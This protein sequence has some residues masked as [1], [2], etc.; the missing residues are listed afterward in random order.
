MPGYIRI[1]NISL[2]L[3]AFNTQSADLY[4][5][6]KDVT[7]S[8]YF[9][10]TTGSA[11]ATPL[12]SKAWLQLHSGQTADLAI[13]D[14]GFIVED[15]QLNEL[16]YGIANRLLAQWPGTVPD[17]AIF[18]LGDRSPL[19]YGAAMAH[20]RE[21]FVNYGVLL[22]AESEDELAAVIGHELSHIL[23]E[24]GKT[25]ELKKNMDNS[26]EL[27]G[28]ARDRYAMAEAIRYNAETIE[29]SIDPSV[30][31]D[32]KKSAEQKLVAD[33]LYARA[34]ATLFSRGNEHDADRLGLDLMVAAG[35]SPMGLKNSLE[36]MAHSYDL[37]TA[38]SEYF[39]SSSE[40]LLQK[41]LTAIDQA[42]E[43]NADK[44]QELNQF[45]TSTGEEFKASALE[46]GKKSVMKLTAQTH[47]VPDKR[48]EQ[49]TAYL[50]DN[51]SRSVRR[52]QP[53]KAAAE[54]F[55]SGH[56]AELITHYSAAN[57]AMQAISLGDQATA[58]QLSVEA[59][60]IP[61]QADPYTRYTAFFNS[62]KKGDT[63]AALANIEAINLD[64]LIPVFVT[65]EFADLLAESGK[66]FE[67]HGMMAQYED[68][69]GT[70]NGYYPP[71][72]KLSSAAKDRESVEQ[73]TN[74]CYEATSEK[75][76]LS[77]SCARASGI[78][79]PKPEK[80]KGLAESTKKL[81]NLFNRNK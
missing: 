35:Y 49:I 45:V 79:R 41:S 33:K 61:T 76:P 38:I 5:Q 13:R 3:M 81:K 15:A 50:F 53:D 2:L 37:S 60:A 74:A 80:N 40:T 8:S 68:Q 31:S 30:E 59:L 34:H 44:T 64:G 39:E 57:Q 26:L 54:Q 47:P 12:T 36:R 71:K 9:T 18:V 21:I 56:I 6:H 19:V 27:L 52:R 42:M 62:R 32:L 4:L 11:A 63:P 16:I 66:T 14:Y 7:R 65:E 55:R 43:K 70:I 25:L 24:H 17:F 48:V 29:F 73:L 22:H 46:F 67:A 10:G 72:I 77:M 51:Y 23:L 69:Y 1:L 78:N 75:S 20:S 28:E 58:E